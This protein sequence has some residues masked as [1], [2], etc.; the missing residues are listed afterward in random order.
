MAERSDPMAPERALVVAGGGSGG[1]VFPGL[2]V[3]DELERRGWRVSWMG[4]PEGMERRLVSGRGMEYEAVVAR[5][6]VGRGAAGRLRALATVGRSALGARRLLRRR[7][8]RAVL[9]TGGYVSAPAVVGAWLARRPAVLLE[10]NAEAGTANRLLSRFARAAAVGWQQSAAGLACAARVTGVPV[11]AAFWQLP[12]VVP[13][14]RRRLLVLGGSQG[15]AQIN[16]L[17]PPAVA[18]LAAGGMRLRVV[19]QVGAAH[20]ASARQAWRAAGG[21]GVEFELVE[22][23]DDVPRAMAGADAVVSRAGAVT[24]AE[25]CAAGR[26]AL[27]VPYGFAGGHQARNAAPLVAAGGARALAGEAAT[28]EACAAELERMLGDAAGLVAMGRALRGL[29]RP[30]AASRIADL[31]EEV[32]A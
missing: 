30:E 2:A 21:E 6:L 1:H 3:A 23:L 26:P 9:G 31:V 16:E 20:L 18:R 4:R 11:R 24:L 15:A 10:P 17:V 29:A 13:A 8:A 25:I 12:E 19:H 5:P 7:G 27:L 22:F 32:A 14:A 28:P